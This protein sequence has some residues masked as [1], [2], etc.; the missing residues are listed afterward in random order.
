[1]DQEALDLPD[2]SEAQR[3]RATADVTVILAAGAGTRL[4]GGGKAL[5]RVRGE[6][7]SERAVQTAHDAGTRPLLVL[8][9]RAAE[10]RAALTRSAGRNVDIVDCPEWEK[11]LSASFRTGVRAAA[12]LGARRIVVVLVDQPGIGASALQAVLRAHTP[13]RIARGAVHGAPTHPVVFELAAAEA[14]AR[15]AEGDEG[16]RAYLQRHRGLVDDVDISDCAVAADIDAPGDIPRWENGQE[17]NANQ[18][19]QQ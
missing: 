9:H 11:G 6:T 5:L 3:S 4:G 15:L 8:G 14:A 18:L 19:F 17:W 1:M 10:A 16:A 12:A 13:G 2:D 7:L